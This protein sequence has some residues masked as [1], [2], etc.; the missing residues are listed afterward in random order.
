[1]PPDVPAVA[2]AIVPATV[3]GEPVTEKIEAAGTLTPTDVTEP[4]PPVPPHAPPESIMFPEASMA[5]QSPLVSVPV[6]VTNLVVLPDLVPTA[7]AVPAP[8]PMTGRFAVSAADEERTEALL[9]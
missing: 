8:P 5:T 4:V 3:T 6:V 9:K 1:M 7:G 2:M